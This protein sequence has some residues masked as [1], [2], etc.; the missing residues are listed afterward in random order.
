MALNLEQLLNSFPD[1]NSGQITPE[2]LRNF[3]ESTELKYDNWT[4]VKP[5]QP[6]GNK[7]PD[8]VGGV[9]T[10]PENTTW[11]I[12][13]QIPL[14]ASLD[15]GDGCVIRSLSG[16]FTNDA[17]G[18][19]VASGA[20]PLFVNSNSQASFEISGLSLGTQ[21]IAG[22]T[23]RLF[24]LTDPS[25]VT[26][27]DVAFQDLAFG[28]I[29]SADFLFMNNCAF[30]LVQDTL[31]ITGTTVRVSISNP[32]IA[33]LGLGLVAD[34]IDLTGL[35]SPLVDL[36]INGG[37]A[38]I[39]SPNSFV[40]VAD[41]D[42][43]N[44]TIVSG[45]VIE[46]TSTGKFFKGVDVTQGI[47]TTFS[48]NS[49]IPNTKAQGGIVQAG[50]S[51]VTVIPGL[52]QWVPIAGDGSDVLTSNSQRFV[53]SG[54]L[55][56]EYVGIDQEDFVAQL[57]LSARRTG[58][59]GNEQQTSFSIAINGNTVEES[60][61]EVSLPFDLPN[62]PK[63]IGIN[64]PTVLNQGDIVT[65]ILRKDAGAEDVIVENIQLLEV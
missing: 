42:V 37:S 39:D 65:P 57:T 44:R 29:D 13:G 53:R 26:F 61:V 6:E 3:V 1:N 64:I 8:P 7:F 62:D 59:G 24:G 21:S 63:T 56:L 27:N 14:S 55:S 4:I 48:G 40:V 15:V 38:S 58:G 16:S 22:G 45:N 54:S 5:G 2:D 23:G 60:G 34:G 30:V 52:G 46:E 33:G 51:A 41:D 43:A 20:I 36:S 32:Q 18:L 28:N 17:L 11:V 9:I 19:D 25:V 31:S 12:N 10:L 50:S 35:S 47:K 49:G